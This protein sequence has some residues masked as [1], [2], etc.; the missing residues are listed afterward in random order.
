MPCRGVLCAIGADDVR[1]LLEVAADATSD[2]EV[3]DAAR[4]ERWDEPSTQ[5]LD[6]AWYGIGCCLNHLV[7]ELDERALAPDSGRCVLGGRPLTSGEDWIVTLWEPAEVLAGVATLD[8]VTRASLRRVYDALDAEEV[9]EYP[10]H[11]DE[12]DFEYVWAYFEGARELCV[13]AAGTGRAIV[14]IVD[15]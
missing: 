8:G 14:F 5:Y 13:R 4:E 7:E 3:V 10:E 12:E 15:Q 2:D 6:K 11:G 1:A 9:K